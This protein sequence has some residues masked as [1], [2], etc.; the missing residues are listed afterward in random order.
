[1]M[2]ETI[3]I[4]LNV[5]GQ[6]RRLRTRVD[7]RLL[8]VVREDLRLTGAKEGCGKGECGAC[9]VIVDGRPV[10]SCLMLAYQ[11]DGSS[12]ETIEGLAENGVL[13]PLQDAFVEE[14][15]A[16]CGICIP[17]MIMAG[18]ALLDRLPNPGPEAIRQGL[19]GNLCR[20]TGYTKIF[21]AVA[22]V[23]GKGPP[24]PRTP[25][26]EPNAPSYYRPRSL[27][28]A[29][30]LMIQR[31]G[32]LRPVAGGTDLLVQ[33][34]D[35]TV[36]RA[37]LFDLSLVPELK[38]IDEQPGHLRIGAAVTHTDI[39]ESKLVDRW[40]PALPM[41]CAWVGGPQIRNRG[42][43]GGNVAHG[44]PA[45][46]TIPPLYVADALVEVVSVSD[47]RDVPI[48]EFFL[49][50][51]KTVLARDEL[52]VGVRIPKRPGVRGAFLRLGQRQAQ[53][54]SKV[55]VAVAMT[56]KD[57]RP[58]WV[59]VALGAVAPTVIRAPETEKA[60]LSG[61]YDAFRQALEAVK[62]EVK[63]IDD[64]RSSREYRRA[65]SA[66]LLERAVRRITE[67]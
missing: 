29:L 21:K 48:S 65:M 60:L 63:P 16:Q 13:H 42:T 49:G 35:G 30:E 40:C 66:V 67:G 39:L 46:D 9:T 36:D 8:D 11:A 44:S 24:A 58:D 43:I 59:R 62:D 34:K 18:K 19:A 52:I 4:A 64:I 5:N 53:A 47:R 32:E 25:P 37:G 50:P 38:G 7:Q 56:F 51:R 41:A 27:E 33:A 28:E 3:E 12:V 15:G 54:I 45:G 22:R 55:S 17:G 57:G 31:A 1:M 2:A 6:A 61:G 10:D 26:T 14:G 20:C 23:A